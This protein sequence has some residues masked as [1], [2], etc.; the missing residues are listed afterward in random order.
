MWKKPGRELR[1]LGRGVKGAVVSDHVHP[2]SGDLAV[3]GAHLGVH[4]V[5][6]RESGGHQ[7]LRA[8]LDPLD[9][10]AGDDRAGDG[11]HVARIHRDLVAEAAADVVAADA[12]HVLGQAR[13]VR[14]DRAVHVGQPGCR[15][16]CPAVRSGVEVRDE[17][18]V[19]SGAGGSA[20]R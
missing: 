14:V 6:A 11:A 3:L 5:V 17:P 2:Q 20:G 7:V 13:H 15:Y 10:G 9:R 1:R 8:I 4:D 18:Q 16:R 12:D 19:S